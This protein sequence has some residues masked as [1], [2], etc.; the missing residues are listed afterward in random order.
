MI[1]QDISDFKSAAMNRSLGGRLQREINAVG[2]YTKV[3]S[4]H[5][6][7]APMSRLNGIDEAALALT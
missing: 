1:N 2:G 5:A 4:Q 3:E 6:L 7:D